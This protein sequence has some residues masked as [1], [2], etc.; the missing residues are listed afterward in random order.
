M[1][2]LVFLKIT[3]HASKNQFIAWEGDI[4]RLKIRGV[5]EKGEVNAELISFLSSV[6]KIPKSSIEIVSGQTSRIKK[7]K[8]QDI[9]KDE[10][11]KKFSIHKI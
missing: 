8:I 3:P 10:L 1:A 2:I 4:L 11:Y 5:P 9:S 6:L 7:V